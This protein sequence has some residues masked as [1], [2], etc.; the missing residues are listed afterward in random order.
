MLKP[1]TRGYGCQREVYHP[2]S[3]HAEPNAI[4]QYESSDEEDEVGE[5]GNETVVWEA[6]KG[7]H[8]L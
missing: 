7:M 2:L 5:V 8:L 3:K 6:K 1:T 4:L